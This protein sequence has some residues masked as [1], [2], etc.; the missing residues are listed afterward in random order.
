MISH[1]DS[2]DYSH[3]TNGGQLSQLLV[4]HSRL[5]LQLSKLS[6]YKPIVLLD[7][8]ATVIA[9]TLSAFIALT[10]GTYLL[11]LKICENQHQ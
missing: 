10:L 4:F 8:L 9:S 7:V 3:I 5:K 2:T 11:F 1:R 6:F